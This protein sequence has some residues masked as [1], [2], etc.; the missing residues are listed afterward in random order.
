MKVLVVE[1]NDLNREIAKEL[2]LDFGVE[3]SEANDGDVA[4]EKIKN[5]HK[6]DYDLVLM[7]IQMP[8]MDGYKATEAIRGLE[9]H[10]MANIPIVAM[11]AN[12]FEEDRQNAF[13]AGMNGH[14]AKPI[15]IVKLKETLKLFYKK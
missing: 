4:V 14:L 3:V 13:K 11:T 7:D 10:E 6:G 9:G 2:L 15:D 5:S 8:M 1:D 12:A